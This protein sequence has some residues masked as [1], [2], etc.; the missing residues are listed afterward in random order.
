[1]SSGEPRTAGG[2]G[3][4]HRRWVRSEPCREA[5]AR[6]LSGGVEEYEEDAEEM[7]GSELATLRYCA[8]SAVNVVLK[9]VDPPPNGRGATG[10]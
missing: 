3:D 10:L 4:P 2:A 6:R 8:S 1:V 7:A 5:A 9:Y